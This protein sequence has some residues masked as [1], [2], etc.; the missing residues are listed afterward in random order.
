[1]R[2]EEEESREGASLEREDGNRREIRERKKR[3]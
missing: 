3:D 2:R 1:M